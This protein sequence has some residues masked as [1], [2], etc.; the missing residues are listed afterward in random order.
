L[1]HLQNPRSRKNLTLIAAVDCRV[2]VIARMVFEGGT[3]SEK[4]ELFIRL[5][6]L[7]AIEGTGRRVFCFDNL[8]A[9]NGAHNAISQAGHIVI[10]RPIHSPDFGAIEIVF[11]WISKFLQH[12][13]S[14]ITDSNLKM[15]IHEACTFVRPVDVQQFF[16]ACH[17]LVPGLP[18]KPYL[19][20]Q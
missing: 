13:D 1:L 14:G 3:S 17:F 6:V 9:H 2:G 4:F 19:G 18:F 16:A 10:N 5:L 11:S 12:H 8:S 20:Q 15:A 7:P